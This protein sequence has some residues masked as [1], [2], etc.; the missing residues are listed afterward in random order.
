MMPDILYAIKYKKEYETQF[1]GQVEFTKH[2]E[3]NKKK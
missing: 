3:K 1:W 2:E